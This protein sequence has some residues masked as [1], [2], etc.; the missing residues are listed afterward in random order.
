V[1]AAYARLS[2]TLTLDSDS[3]DPTGG[4]GE[5]VDPGY[6]WF[7]QA[8]LDL[9]LD[10]EFDGHL[11]RVGA[12]ANTAT[13]AY[14]EANLRVAWRPSPRLELSLVGRDLLHAEHVEFVPP[15]SR[16]TTALERA[17]YTRISMAF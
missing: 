7:L 5:A 2:H 1:T 3:R 4:L 10:F 6:Q 17:V 11:R 9:P 15:S 8:R 13:P 12:I 16:R 14:T